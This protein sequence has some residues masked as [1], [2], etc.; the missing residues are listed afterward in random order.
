MPAGELN[1]EIVSLLDR[2]LN[3]GIVADG[4]EKRTGKKYFL[5]GESFKSWASY[6]KA[7]R[8]TPQRFKDRA[9]SRADEKK[10]TE[11]IR[12]RSENEMRRTLNW[13][14]LTWFGFGAVIGTGIFV[15]TGQEAHNDAGPAIVVSYALSGFSCMLCVFCY[16]EFAV[17]IPVAGG[18]FAYL[19]VELGDLIA[20]I[21]AGNIILECIVGGAAVARSWTSYFATLLNYSPDDF[22]IH[23]NLASGFNLLDPIALTVVLLASLT[24][25][26]ST[27][28]T[29][30]LNWIA[31]IVNSFI[32]LFIIVAGFINANTSNLTPFLPYG[33]KGVFK[34]AAIVYFAYGGFETIATMAEETKNPSK[35]IPLGLLCSM[36]II[37][38]IY[39]LMALALV[40]MQ[41][42]IDLDVNAAYSLAFQSIG[43]KWAKY[44]VALG[45]L[46]GI[47][48]VLLVGAVGRARYMTHIARTHMIPPWF[49]LVNEKTGTPINGTAVLAIAT[50]VVAF[51]SSL[52]VLSNLLSISTLFIFMLISV[53]LLVRRHYV[54]EITC[55]KHAFLLT[56]FIVV[57]ICC[58]IGT[59]V[60]WA[61]SSGWIGY[62]IALPVWFLA[63][64]GLA[65]FVPQCREAKVW[66]VPMVPW[67]PSLSI[68]I[69]VFL[70]GSLDYESFIRFGICTAL[71]LV[72][73]VFFGLHS[74]FDAF[75][76]VGNQ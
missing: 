68:F 21:A 30:T 61:L 18:S 75:H 13:W 76:D 63:T 2:G 59:S 10:E 14:D 56:T 37:T 62:C 48:T 4:G 49:G 38:V 60:F 73:Y 50:A 42:Y 3:E 22:R 31:S 72:Y 65:V 29:S 64:A 44:I 53:A 16:T 24:A 58:S 36:S 23:T 33:V 20:F 8:Q 32:I 69:N 43:W 41:S 45:A 51:F 28:V 1:N 9:L 34:A 7:L 74:S 6:G 40:L 71:M 52:D 11:E 25:I 70:M 35:D 5:P 54:K 67:I 57:I 66:G 12:K 26:L 27:R 46:K 39:C 19:R 15:L 47:T 17:E 55:R